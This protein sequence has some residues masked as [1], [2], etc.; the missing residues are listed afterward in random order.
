M[1]ALSRFVSDNWTN[2]SFKRTLGNKKTGQE[3]WVAPTWVGDHQRRLT[4]YAILRAYVDN[5]ARHF[6]HTQDEKKRDAYREYGDADLVVQSILAALLGEDQH[7]ITEGAAESDPTRPNDQTGGAEVEFQTWMRE[8]LTT[9]RFPLKMVEAE[10]DAVSLGDGVYVWGW[11]EDKQRP[12]LRVYDPG[13]Y[14]PVIT[15]GNEDDYPAK[16]HI[17][18]EMESDDLPSQIRIRRITYEMGFI[19]EEDSETGDLTFPERL[20]PWNDKPSP[21]TCYMT[22]ATWIL[23]QGGPADVYDFSGGTAVYETY[24]DPD[25]GEVRPYNHVDIGLDFIPVIHMPNTISLKD[26]YGKSSLATILQILDDIANA[27][28][29]LNAASGTTGTPPVALSGAIIGQTKPSYAPGEVWQLGENGDLKILD[30]SGSLDALLKYI[31]ALLSRL[32]INSRLPESIM[33]R[34]KPSEVP[35][36]IALAL[37]FGPLVS[38]VG[39]MR[40]IRAEKHPLILKFGH[41]IALAGGMEGVPPKWIPTTVQ[42]GSFLPNDVKMVVDMVIQLLNAENPGVSI[43]TAVKMLTIAGLPIEDAVAEVGRIT[44]RDFEG[45]KALAEAT[46]DPK[47]V[48]EYLQREPSDP[49]LL[50]IPD[51]PD[52]NQLP[53]GPNGPP[54]P[55]E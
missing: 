24:R 6:L 8:L 1:S 38:M 52:P 54:N 12:R 27:D 55:P 26:H 17:A 15:D 41:R 32:S 34:I 5:A 51:Q 33:G 29:D 2:I 22:D 48:F 31:E 39:Q 46:K 7:I 28:S 42:L 20:Y 19:V 47:L 21:W 49:K 13:F 36:G 9:E 25:T 18:W 44:G 23:P 43:E 10:R 14:F 45:A 11:S 3:S 40:M 37:S 30:T 50:E 53:P 35:S 4:A 16:I